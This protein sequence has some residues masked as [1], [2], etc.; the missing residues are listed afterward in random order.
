[1]PRGS[2]PCRSACKHPKEKPSGTDLRFGQLRSGC[3]RLLEKHYVPPGRCAQTLR[4]VVGKPAPDHAVGRNIIPFL[5]GHFAGF[6][7]D[8]Y[9]GIG[10]ECRNAH[11]AILS[12][13]SNSLTFSMLSAC[14]PRRRLHNKPFDSMMRT[15]GSSEI[16][17]RS[18][19]IS[20]LA[21][22]EYPQ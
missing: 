17:I 13:S 3:L 1:M 8:A 5:A 7:A 12:A 16:A 15:L 14:L 9:G 22:P 20:P 10:Q 11:C 6:A 2:P 18:L 21:N 4:V 19:P